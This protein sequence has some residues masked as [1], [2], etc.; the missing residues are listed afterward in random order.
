MIGP[1]P[2]AAATTPPPDR[3]A[4]RC[5]YPGRAPSHGS[6]VLARRV[7]SGR[8]W[9]SWARRLPGRPPPEASKPLN[10][11]ALRGTS[12]DGGNRTRVRDRVAVAS[13]SV[14]GALISSSNR[15]AGGVYE[16][17]LPEMSPVWRERTS[18]G[19]PTFDPAIPPRSAGGGPE[20]PRLTP[21]RRRGHAHAMFPH[22]CVAR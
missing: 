6:L 7:T 4:G 2:Q 17:Q 15:L 16:D 14:S 20:N 9:R 10:G 21:R 3:R 8:S 1:R 18:P 11:A 22:L 13:T 5:V 12:G 19:E